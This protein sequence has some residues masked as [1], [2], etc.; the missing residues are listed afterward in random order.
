MGV[1]RTFTPSVGINWFTYLSH[2]YEDGNSVQEDR[3]PVGDAELREGEA[4]DVHHQVEKVV[5]GQ[6]AHQEVEVTHH[7]R[8]KNRNR[9]VS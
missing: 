4:E 6:R 3:V 5:D 9:D 2:R 7:L 8:K 1:E